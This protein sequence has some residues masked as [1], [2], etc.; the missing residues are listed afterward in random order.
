MDTKENL[1]YYANGFS[2]TTSYESGEMIVAFTQ[3]QP[4]FDAS[5]TEFVQTDPREVA[6]IIV[7]F[8]LGVKLGEILKQATEET[9]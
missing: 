1:T 3:N 6:T 4:V 9:K 7:P 8:G 2:L 5:K